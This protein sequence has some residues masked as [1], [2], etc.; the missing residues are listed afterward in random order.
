MLKLLKKI[1]FFYCVIEQSPT[2]RKK[3]IDSLSTE[4]SAQQY[5]CDLHFQNNEIRDCYITNLP[6]GEINLLSKGRITLTPGS[7]PLI[8]NETRFPMVEDCG[9]QVDLINISA[10]FELQCQEDQQQQ[11]QQQTIVHLISEKSSND[12]SKNCELLVEYEHE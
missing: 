10:D 1:F 2:K 5:V 9:K 6:N 4:L 8:A 7:V 12:L 3:W 11:Q